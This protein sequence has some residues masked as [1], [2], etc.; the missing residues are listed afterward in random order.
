M[1]S[2]SPTRIF[3]RLFLP[4]N[5][6]WAISNLVRFWRSYVAYSRLS[7][8]RPKYRRLFPCLNDWVA[9]TPVGYYFFQDCWGFHNVARRK[10]SLHVDIGS[11]ALLVGC[12]AAVA[13]TISVDF[14][15]LVARTFGLKSMRG[16]IVELPFKDNSL[17]SITSLC[18]IEHIGLGRY[19]EP[20]DPHGTARAAREL[21]RVLRPGGHLYVSVPCGVRG[22]AF[23]AHRI[24]SR[25]EVVRLFDALKLE[26]FV[27][28][29]NHGVIE[30]PEATDP[31]DFPVGLFRFTK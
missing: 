3:L 19:G 22:V 13:P 28:V 10:P 30:S 16:S 7:D 21:G 17:E 11:T 8:E 12:F 25:E 4:P 26:E 6:F 15:P 1:S 18:V 27:L 2:P 14:R 31:V 24:F 5:P 20:L 29:G 9:E 23:N